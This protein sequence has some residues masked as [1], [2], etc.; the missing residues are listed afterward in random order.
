MDFI[1]PGAPGSFR[2]HPSSRFGSLNRSSLCENQYTTLQR[3]GDTGT[4]SRNYTT[5]TR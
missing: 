5:G 4:K 2:M 3:T 1:V